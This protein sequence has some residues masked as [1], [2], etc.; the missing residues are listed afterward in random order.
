[1]DHYKSEPKQAPTKECP[2]CLGRIP[3]AARR[4]SHCTAQLEAPSEAV[5]AAMRR[6]AA[7]SGEDV[8]DAAAEILVGRLQ[9]R[10]EDDRRAAA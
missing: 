6:V 4:C 9:G 5:T 7:P 10:R 3:K 2:E 8:A 1:M